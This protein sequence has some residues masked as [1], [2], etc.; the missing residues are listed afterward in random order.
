MDN[1]KENTLV[2]DTRQRLDVSLA[3]IPDMG[4]RSQAQKAIRAGNVTVDGKVRTR[5]SYPVVPGAVIRWKAS[6][7]QTPQLLPQALPID[8]V[9]EDES[10]LVINKSARMP[11]HPGAGRHSGTLVNAVL[12]HV[13]ATLPHAPD[14]AFRPG[15]VHRL[16]MDTTGL[17]VVAKN[18]E[19]HRALQSQFEARTV[20][21]YYTG[22]VWGIPDPRTGSI[23]A[24]IGRSRRNRTLMSVHSGGR[25]ALTHYETREI[26]GV[27]AVV[28]FRLNTGRTHQ[29]RVHASHLG[30]PLVGDAA[31][32][33]AT[34]KRG[35]VT[36]NRR[37]FFTNVFNVLDRQA[38]H[39]QSLGFTHP[40]SGEDME[41]V[42]DLPEDMV[43]AIEQL[44]KDPAVIRG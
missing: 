10:V 43:W 24:P 36:A 7:V 14:E 18:D 9:Y 20:T 15:I 37:A 26:L 3:C 38:L 42:T 31:Y 35:I 23:D 17:L 11:V 44:R 34:I 1:Q 13:N 2:A 19:A 12:H 5:P 29:I 40:D 39:A 8:V 32:G 28:Q 41:F 27:T 22:I 30:H 25:K 21:R 33:G 16:D 6:V 4:S